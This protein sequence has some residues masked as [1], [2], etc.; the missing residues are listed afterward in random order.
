MLLDKRQTDARQNWS[1]GTIKNSIDLGGLRKI[2]DL[3]RAAVIGDCRQQVVLHDCAQ[4]Y[5][6]TEA[7]RFALCPIGELRG[8]VCFA[9]VLGLI[10]P[11][12]VARQCLSRA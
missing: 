1:C 4:S 2:S 11:G 7:I 12:I 9:R 3:C 8:S 6:W 5:V 10:L